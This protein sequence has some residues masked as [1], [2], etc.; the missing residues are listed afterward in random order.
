MFG[1]ELK[2]LI[3]SWARGHTRGRRQP[4]IRLLFLGLAVSCQTRVVDDSGLVS[5]SPA[6]CGCVSSAP[7]HGLDPVL[8]RR[9][10]PLASN[11]MAHRQSA[12][13]ATGDGMSG[14]MTG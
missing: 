11:W 4:G 10:T 14:M 1:D 8:A 13:I 7:I 9:S 6:S 12:V 5:V 2:T 3:G